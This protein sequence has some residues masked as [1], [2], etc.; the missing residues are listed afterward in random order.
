MEQIQLK[1]K[2]VEETMSAV[3]AKGLHVVSP[4]G[5]NIG[6]AIDVR[7]DPQTFS[8]Q[9]VLVKKNKTPTHACAQHT[10]ARLHNRMRHI[11]YFSITAKIPIEKAC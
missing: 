3:D 11:Y 10:K 6:K 1:G 2:L 7:I 4:S 8:F 9:G 5:T